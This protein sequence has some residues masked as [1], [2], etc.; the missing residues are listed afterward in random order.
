[1][2]FLSEYDIVSSGTDIGD[3][4]G[5][6]CGDGVGD[7]NEDEASLCLYLAAGGSSYDADGFIST[8]L[9]ELTEAVVVS[10]TR[11]GS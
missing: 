9:D 2:A 1:L 6:R 5:D 11:I 7:I 3:C 8:L 4:G 10:R